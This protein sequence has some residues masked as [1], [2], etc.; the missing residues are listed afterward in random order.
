M[1]N[2][3][4]N[5]RENGNSEIG[6][7]QVSRACE[8]GKNTLL[9]TVSRSDGRNGLTSSKRVHV[10]S[11]EWP[12]ILPQVFSLIAN[13]YHGR[14]CRFDMIDFHLAQRLRLLFAEKVLFFGLPFLDQC[15]IFLLLVLQFAETLLLA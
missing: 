1:I 15:Q 7:V 5:E 2:V 9:L 14:T 11:T 3:R 10:G 6:L 8:T 12:S 4:V 13:L